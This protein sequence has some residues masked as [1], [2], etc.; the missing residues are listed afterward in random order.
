[1]RSGSETIY[2]SSLANHLDLACNSV[3][4]L[5]YVAK[6]GVTRFRLPGD[7]LPVSAIF[8]DTP[9]PGAISYTDITAGYDTRSTVNLIESTNYGIDDQGVNEENDQLTVNDLASQ[10]TY[11]VWRSNVALNLYDEAPYVGSFEARLAELLADHRAPEP[12]VSSVRFN[13]RSDETLT[14]AL[15]VGDRIGV[16][17]R[18]EAYDN[19]IV[20][21]SHDI[22]PNRWMVTLALQPV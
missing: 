14:G 11:G 1:M 4:A 16:Y 3:G 19:Q 17:Y 7:A 5:W 8:T 21:I 18:G 13:A 10:A 15:E 22:T 2:E 6:D 9:T 12:Q 20:S